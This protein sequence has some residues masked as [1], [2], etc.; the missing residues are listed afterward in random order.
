MDEGLANVALI[1]MRIRWTPAAVADLQ[2]IHD[3]L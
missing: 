1:G 2:N 3:Y